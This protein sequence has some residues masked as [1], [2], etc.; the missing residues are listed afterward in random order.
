MYMTG[1]QFSKQTNIDHSKD[2][3]MMKVQL[4]DNKMWADYNFII[5]KISHCVTMSLAVHSELRMAFKVGMK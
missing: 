5:K 1:L 4:D 2:R 3:N